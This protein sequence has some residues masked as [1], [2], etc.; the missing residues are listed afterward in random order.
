MAGLVEGSMGDDEATEILFGV[1]AS[2]ADTQ[3]DWRNLGAA[4][5]GFELFQD[6]FSQSFIKFIEATD[7]IALSLLSDAS[8]SV[9]AAGLLRA[10]DLATEGMALLEEGLESGLE[11]ASVRSC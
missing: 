10:T 6:L 4:P 3:E 9:R 1:S 8:D 5:P 11:S 7:L 2:F